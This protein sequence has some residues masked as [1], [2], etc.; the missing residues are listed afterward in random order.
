[1]NLG[2]RTKDSW[3]RFGFAQWPAPVKPDGAAEI[4]IDQPG[5]GGALDDA[6]QQHT[7]EPTCRARCGSPPRLLRD[8][9]SRAA[10]CGRNAAKS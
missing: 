5:I 4:R 10:R 1:M 7:V 9:R 6:R 8:Q 3:D 2:F